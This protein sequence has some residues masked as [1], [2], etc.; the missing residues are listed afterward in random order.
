M[1]VP[2]RQTQTV[3]S[4]AARTRLEPSRVYLWRVL[5][6]GADGSVIGQS[7]MRELRTP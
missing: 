1:L 3:L 2:G 6:I 4:G 7:P 5:A